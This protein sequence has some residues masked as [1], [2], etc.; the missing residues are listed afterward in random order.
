M[1]EERTQ[2]IS[3]VT[4]LELPQDVEAEKAVLG[5]MLQLEDAVIDVTDRLRWEDFYLKE[6]QEIYKA[7]LDLYRQ[8]IKIDLNTAY[9]KLKSRKTAEFVG[10]MSYLSRLYDGAIVPTNA[11]FY[12]ETVLSKSNMRQLIREADEMRSQAYDGQRP[13]DQ[14]LDHAEQRIFEI[15]HKSQKRNYTDINEVLVENIKHIQELE[16]NKGQLPGIT[17]GFTDLD[18]LLGGLHK[19]DLIILAARPG[20]G[21]TAFALNVAGNA[22]AAGAS[23]IIFSMEMSDE[24]LGERM[25]ATAACVEMEKIKRGEL[26]PDEWMSLSEAQD[27]F[28]NVKLVIDDTSDISVLEIKN[29]C[30]RRKAEAGLDLIVIDY[31]QLMS[32]QGFKSGDRVNEI[33]AITR[34]IKILAKELDC[35]VILLSQLSRDIEKRTNHTPQLSDLRESGSIEQDADIVIFLKRDGYYTSE[36]E[37]VDLSRQNNTCE[38]Y[39]SK[40]R[41]GSTGVVELAWIGKYTKFGNLERNLL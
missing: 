19:T 8:N 20:M 35:A 3:P 37:E 29:K 38:V 1:D 18:K 25:L 31:L 33:S 15:A 41:S 27:G 36:D 23:V 16:Q 6:H 28:E 30:R 22:A 11:K 39:V 26:T 17:T 13:A 12:A 21:K 14:I 9:S 32:Q 4:N 40:H 7:F 2:V 5:S 34:Q 24:Q 10:G